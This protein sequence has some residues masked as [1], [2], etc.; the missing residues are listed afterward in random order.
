MN[1]AICR[2]RALWLADSILPHEA[3]LRAWLCGRRL[4][5]RMEVDDIVQE[6]YAVLVSM[7]D[8]GQIRNP[9]AYLFTTAQSVVL[10]HLRR[11]RIVS[12]DTVAEIDRLPGAVD[13]RSPERYTDARQ[14]LSMIGALISSLPVKCR[15]AF[16]L[17]K[18]EGL[19]QRQVAL[20]MGIS[21]NTVEKHV[22]KGLRILMCAFRS[23][24]TVDAK[25]ASGTK[26]G[27]KGGDSHVK[28]TP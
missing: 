3:A 16:M 8:V 20:R 11:A 1:K 9:R 5:T 28:T 12:I 19:S 7:D 14:Q 13:E 10:Q 27:I 26:S 21:E 6:T 25:L 15:Q 2:Q 4:G 17:R 23:D 18:I 24:G 22:G